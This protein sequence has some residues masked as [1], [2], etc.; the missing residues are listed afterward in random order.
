MNTTRCP[1]CHRELI[2]E[3]VSAH[4]CK[5]QI[6]AVSQIVDMDY[7]WWT[8]SDLPKYGRVLIVKTKDGTLYRMKPSP[9]W[10]GDSD[11]PNTEQS[12]F[13]DPSALSG[14]WDGFPAHTSP[15]GP[16]QTGFISSESRGGAA[17][18]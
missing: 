7:E 12:L 15:G 13:A 17:L 11:N 1:N 6:G 4:N 10:D 3:E 9:K 16:Q 14:V 8:T 5:A 2:A 18:V